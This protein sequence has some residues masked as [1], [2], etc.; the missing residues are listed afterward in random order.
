MTK[1]LVEGVFSA[2]VTPRDENGNLSESGLQT[3]LDYLVD[4]GIRGFAINGATGEF[5]LTSADE[6][7]RILK[8]VSGVLNGRAEFMVGVGAGDVK[9]TCRLGDIAIEAGAKG[10]LLPVPGFFPYAQDDVVSFVRAVANSLRAP[11]LLYNLPQFTTGIHPQS[12]LELVSQCENIVGIKDSSGSLDTL[13]LLRDECP[14]ACRVV[15]ND[16]ALPAA[17]NEGLADG[18]ISGVACVLPALIQGMFENGAR[19]I[20]SDAMLSALDQ[21][22]RQL[23]TLPTPWGLKVIG[24]ALGI[25]KASFPF[26]LSE[27]RQLQRE[28][29]TEWFS[30]YNTALSA[31][32][33]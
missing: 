10:L 15:G 5:P 31:I 25:A 3:W 11:I 16:G 8:V 21:F 12:T 14:E 30:Q 13:R 7:K 4:R 29:M 20:V 18:V 6:L 22:I 1:K 33:S 19:G 28:E 24:E 32:V 9:T 2:V 26:P 17:L 27:R 23:D